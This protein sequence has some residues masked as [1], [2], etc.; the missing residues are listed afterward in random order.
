MTVVTIKEEY[1]QVLEPLGPSID[2][3]IRRLAIE[4]ANQRISELQRK[5]QTWEAT[6]QSSFDLFAFRTATD[7]DY[8]ASLNQ[9][10]ETSQWEADLIAWEFY[11]KELD[12]WYS[13]LRSILMAS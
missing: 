8:V 11:A 10:P 12:E 4:R 6:Y 3:A 9:A 2:E 1:A 13:R 7:E 5:V